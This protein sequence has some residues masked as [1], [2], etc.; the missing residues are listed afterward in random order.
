MKKGPG[1]MQ[2]N[3][4]NKATT[5]SAGSTV[6]RDDQPAVESD[7][8]DEMFYDYSLSHPFENAC[9]YPVLDKGSF[10]AGLGL[11]ASEDASLDRYVSHMRR[12]RCPDKG[13]YL[14]TQD[15]DGSLLVNGEMR[16]FG[17]PPQEPFECFYWPIAGALK[18]Q[19]SQILYQQP[20]KLVGHLLLT[21]VSFQLPKSKRVMINHHQ[22]AVKCYKEGRIAEENLSGFFILEISNCLQFINKPM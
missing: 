16:P 15:K 14:V 22:F 7:N 6:G 5:M 3:E 20:P 9:R 1:N 10:S 4:F 19:T 21:D 17:G 18:P 11:S 2:D 12:I 8:N 13:P